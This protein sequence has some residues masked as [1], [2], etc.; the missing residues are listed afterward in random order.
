M[1]VILTTVLTCFLPE[2]FGEITAFCV[3][4]KEDSLYCSCEGEHMHVQ[5]E[6]RKHQFPFTII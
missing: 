2:S 3:Q 1:V 6:S 4:I 5:T